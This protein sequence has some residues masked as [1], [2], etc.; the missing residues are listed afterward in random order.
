MNGGDIWSVVFLG[1]V[2]VIIAQRVFGRKK[3]RIFVP[4]YQRAVK[5]VDGAFASILDPGSYEPPGKHEQITIVDMR[6][7]PIVV[8]RLIYHD[9]IQ[10]PS[11]ISIVTELVISDP[12]EALT[13]LKNLAND[14]A[15]IARD[16]LRSMVSKRIAD[17][18]PESREKLASDI[19]TALNGELR[20]YGVQLQNVEVTELWSRTIK[21]PVMTGAN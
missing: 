6:P 11:V 13:K 18:T 1:A 10:A 3:P 17:P 21:Q 19:A 15:A 16:Q 5:F 12:V 14:S 2:L 20:K 8:E 7:L 4:D 9:A